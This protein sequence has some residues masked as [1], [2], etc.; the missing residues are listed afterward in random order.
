LARAVEEGQWEID[1]FLLSC[2]ALGRGYETALLSTALRR[3][4]SLGALSVI[5]RYIP[6]GRNSQV[7]GFYAHHGALLL[8]S[9][10]D[11]SD[12]AAEIVYRFDLSQ[13]SKIVKVPAWIRL[14]G[15]TP[16]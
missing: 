2:R 14:G 7:Q 15:D 8:P 13:E 6:T 9:S 10:T 16:A 4:R 5:G 3:L 1:S 12:P 11:Q